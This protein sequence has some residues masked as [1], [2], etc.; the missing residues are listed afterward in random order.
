MTEIHGSCD[1]RFAA[2]RYALADNLETGLDIG[3]SVAV[4]VD[5]EPVV[6]I[7]SG[8]RDEA[9][10]VP[11]DADTIVNVFSITKTMVA[12]CALI[13]ADRGELDL[14]APVARYWPEF[15]AAGKGCIE[16]RHLLGHTAGLPG[17]EQ[18]LASEELADWEKCT[19]SLAAQA[20]W[21]E[22]GTASGYHSLTQGY[23]VGEVI[24]RITGVSVGRFFAETV[25]G[26]LQADFYIGLPP[27]HDA[28]VAPMIPPRTGR[29]EDGLTALGVRALAKPEITGELT[30]EEWWQRA[31]I[32][33]ANGHG[34]AR[35][36]A[37]IQSVVAC[38]GEARGHRL[39]SPAGVE[40]IFRRQSNGT[41]LV[42]GVPLCFGIGFGLTSETMPL[43]PHA[44]SWGGYGG[45][46][47]LNDLDT[48]LTIAYVMN[49]MEAGWL[50]DSRGASIAFAAAVAL[51]RIAKRAA[52]ASGA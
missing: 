2:V 38:R 19:T 25:A 7:W 3:A 14:N 8:H 39:L 23:L 37:A 32:P 48:R 18:P 40:A 28:R 46:M 33:A 43:A 1:E 52:R 26:P 45:S 24:R 41:D 44:C 16:V 15:G 6:D 49:R 4:F 27:E 21:W 11:W 36:V 51:A 35:S 30:A 20:P 9:R 34:N 42:L 47:I 10:T 17:W 5:G 12:L 50:G 22:P 29:R 31:E 13:L